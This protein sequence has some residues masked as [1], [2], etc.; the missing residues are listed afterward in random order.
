MFYRCAETR[1]ATTQLICTGWMKSCAYDPIKLLEKLQVFIYDTACETAVNTILNAEAKDLASLS[2]PEIRAFRHGIDQSLLS[3]SDHKQDIA[4]EAIFWTRVVF[5]RAK[6]AAEKDILTN[7]IFPDIAILSQILERHVKMLMKAI[8]EQNEEEED[9]LTCICQQLLQLAAMVDLEEGSRRHA[10]AVMK[11]MLC[12]VI[13]P[14][15]LIEGCVLL[16]KQVNYR[17]SDYLNQVLEVLDNL[18]NLMESLGELQENHL[19]RILSI[20]IVVLENATSALASSQC[21][22]CITNQVLMA[23]KHENDLIREAAVSCFGKLGFF[24][25]Q[26]TVLSGYKPLLLTIASDTEENVEIRAQALLALSDW[27]ILM[28]DIDSCTPV[29]QSNISVSRLVSNLMVDSDEPAF[30]CIA[31][32][33]ASKLLFSGKILNNRWLAQ[34]VII[35]FD[36]ELTDLADAEEEN[37]EETAVKQPGSAVRLQQLLSIF[38]PAYCIKSQHGSQELVNSVTP[39]LE[40]ASDKQSRKKKSRGSKSVPYAKMLGYI[41]ETVRA[42]EES[43]NSG[44]ETKADRDKETPSPSDV[45]QLSSDLSIGMQLAE[46]LSK[47][48]GDLSVTVLRTLCKILGACSL[49]ESEPVQALARLKR[50]VEELGM[51]ITD[52]TC[53][54]AIAPL[55]QDLAEVASNDDETQANRPQQEVDNN[56]DAL[57][58]ALDEV[59]LS[60]TDMSNQQIKSN[61]RTSLMPKNS[62][63]SA[64]QSGTRKS[65]RLKGKSSTS[66]GAYTEYS[67]T[68]EDEMHANPLQNLAESPVKKIA[69]RYRSDQHSTAFDEVEI[70]PGAMLNKENR[71]S[72]S[73]AK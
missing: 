1:E 28:G 4:A 10:I 31:A 26:E 19:L 63:L 17:E 49:G 2:E 40:I 16:L 13:S 41:S 62:H 51:E 7:Q 64:E 37:A 58:T 20:I 72:G 55:E 59:K 61:T 52:V 30:K 48:S 12:S 24:S 56:I 44:G 11:N 18:G 6:T 47:K 34:L 15:D 66:C 43:R 71:D 42:A 29:R 45:P 68:D 57:V 3:I 46:F 27:S 69:E 9:R 39:M 67:D 21:I 32:E 70:G 36:A 33:V 22:E 14:D 50:F 53:L 38:F 35:F 60:S 65:S 23:V 5:S 25:N 8:E 54:R 73:T